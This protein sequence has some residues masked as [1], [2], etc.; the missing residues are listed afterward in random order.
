M[1][2]RRDTGVKIKHVFPST[3]ILYQA[4]IPSLRGEQSCGG[5]VVCGGEM[6]SVS[7]ATRGS[8]KRRA[9]HGGRGIQ[10][11]T[12][13]SS[14]VLDLFLSRYYIPVMLI[15]NGGEVEDPH[16]DSFRSQI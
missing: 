10:L 5:G 11:Y 16:L 15:Y 14:N 1:T 12:C 6:V 3:D 4:D 9:P 8:M 2:L 13:Y 7:D